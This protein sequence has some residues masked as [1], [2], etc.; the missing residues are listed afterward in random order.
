M[1]SVAGTKNN[2]FMDPGEDVNSSGR[3][4]PG[5]VISVNGGATV[6]TV[7]T[8]ATGFT[9]INLQ[10][11]E[12]YAYWVEIDLKVAANVAGTESSTTANFLVPGLA[13]DYND[14]TVAP[15]GQFSPFGNVASCIIKN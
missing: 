7:R 11:A 10:Y 8:D 5:N 4:E 15:A 14:E 13:S 9:L 6:T 3:L 2:G 1:S 12:S